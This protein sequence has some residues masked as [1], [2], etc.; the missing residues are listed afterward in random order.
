LSFEVKFV[1]EQSHLL[2][3]ITTFP[4]N[5]EASYLYRDSEAFII[6][7]ALLAEQR[8]KPNSQITFSECDGFD[9]LIRKVV[10]GT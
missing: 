9:S 8:K 4:L 2:I 7:G 3:I 6:N 10:R 1:A 5:Y